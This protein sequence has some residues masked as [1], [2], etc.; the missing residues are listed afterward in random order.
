[1]VLEPDLR[2]ERIVARDAAGLAKA[3]ADAAQTAADATVPL[4]KIATIPARSILMNP[5]G[6]AAVPAATVIGDLPD[7]DTSDESATLLLGRDK[8]G[9]AGKI[10]IAAL[11]ALR[12]L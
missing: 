10:T 5:S 11:F 12:G 6:S 4:A 8:N 3:A 2:R 9:V 7:L 1:M